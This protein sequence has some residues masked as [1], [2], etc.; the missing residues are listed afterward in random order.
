MAGSGTPLSGWQR[1]NILAATQY[2]REILSRAPDQKVQLVYDGLLEVIEPSRR[3]VRQQREMTAARAAVPVREQRNGSDRRA[4]VDRRKK[5]REE[6][7]GEDRRKA[8]RRQ[9]ERRRGR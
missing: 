9:T 8:E 2:L 5:T 1:A 7:G 3:V 4:G 6:P